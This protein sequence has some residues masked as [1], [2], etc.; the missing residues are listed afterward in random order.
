MFLSSRK[1]LT[2]SHWPIPKSNDGPYK[3]GFE[4]HMRPAGRRLPTPGLEGPRNHKSVFHVVAQPRFAGCV[5][6]LERKVIF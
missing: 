4:G 6:D 1:L 2:F 3:K 5:T